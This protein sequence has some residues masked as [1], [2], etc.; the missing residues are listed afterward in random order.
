MGKTPRYSVVI[1]TR[2]RSH[3]LRH[4]I[5][6]CLAQEFDDVEF[7]VSDNGSD[8]ATRKLVEEF[9][10]RRLRYVHTPQPLAMTDSWEFAVGQAT[11]EFVTVIG[12]DD[13][14]LLHALPQI[15]RVLQMTGGKVLRW[16]AAY[17]YWPCVPSRPDASPNRLFIPLRRRRRFD[18]I[19]RRAGRARLAKAARWKTTYATLPMIY[20]AMVHRSVLAKLREETGRVFYS[21]SP[22]VYS[23][24]AIA[25]AAGEFLS[26]DTPI[27]L[28]GTSGK[29]NALNFILN[30][31][32][33]VVTDFFKLNDEAG[34]R[35]H[36]RAP[37]LKLISP[38]EADS[39]LHAQERLFPTDRRLALDRR[40]LISRCVDDL[41]A[42]DELEWQQALAKMRASLTDN[43]RL[44]RWFDRKYA[45]MARRER[46]PTPASVR[47]KRYDG[48]YLRLDTSEFGVTNV[49]EA[50]E[51]FEKLMGYRAESVDVRS[52][53]DVRVSFALI[54]DRVSAKLRT[55]RGRL[56]APRILRRRQSEA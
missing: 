14:L 51:L 10:D 7:L 48:S 43:A 31:P 56:I 36:E 16:E 8:G 26:V 19:R 3:T 42:K 15:D 30:E 4:S 11:G 55:I 12:D 52:V 13:G 29:S 33:T 53:K 23:A 2:D 22:D 28:G 18:R 46:R 39:Y 37:D 34:I 47:P 20:R 38:V 54:A 49:Y 45:S 25:H 21:L 44:V 24:F 6:T 40:K 9:S 27:G 35:W 32:S 5:R 50:A 17:Y 41:Q 1:P